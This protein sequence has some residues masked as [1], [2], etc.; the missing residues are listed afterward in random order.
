M[1]MR[2]TEQR[3]SG[4]RPDDWAEESGQLTDG[5]WFVRD[6]DIINR[7]NNILYCKQLCHRAPAGDGDG[8]DARYDVGIWDSFQ[9][10]YYK[11]F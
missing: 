9:T 7:I 11:R 4:G 5:N 1:T 2:G 10:F 6:I 8:L 3:R